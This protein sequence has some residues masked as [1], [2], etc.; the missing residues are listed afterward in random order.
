[1]QGQYGHPADW[2]RLPQTTRAIAFAQRRH[3]GQQLGAVRRA[4]AELEH[5]G[6]RSA[7]DAKIA[8]RTGL[9]AQVV[10]ALRD[11]P[12]VTASLDEPVGEDGISLDE[13]L[14]DEH[15]V[16]PIRHAIESERLDLLPRLLRLLPD[17]H[18]RVLEH[19][20]GLNN[21]PPQS[22]QQIGARLGVSEERS[23]QLEREALHRLHTIAPAKRTTAR[24]A[25][26]A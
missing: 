21:T 25:R 4:E 26:A 15:A 24:L 16:D 14:A 6:S 9:T 23:R 1:L 20:Y 7:S 17:R 22:H 2:T 3:A 13:L 18:R 19:H 11:P 10:S 5:G 8:D 12:R